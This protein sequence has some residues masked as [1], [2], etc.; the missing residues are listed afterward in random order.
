MGTQYKVQVINEDTQGL[1]KVPTLEKELADEKDFGC[2]A[3]R[4][5][6][7]SCYGTDYGIECKDCI[8]LMDNYEKIS[9]GEI[10]ISDVLYG[11]E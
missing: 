7:I 8:F 10:R 1:L 11:G 5:N 2:M 3:R 4:H 9:G 6:E